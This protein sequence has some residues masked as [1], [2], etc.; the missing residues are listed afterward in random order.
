MQVVKKLV[1]VHRHYNNTKNSVHLH[2]Y[3]RGMCDRRG[4]GPEIAGKNLNFGFNETALLVCCV[5]R[6]NHS[7]AL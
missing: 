7:T 2:R 3:N 6:P 4:K 1:A 5:Q